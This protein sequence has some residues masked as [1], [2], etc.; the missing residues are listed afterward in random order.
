MLFKDSEITLDFDKKTRKLILEAGELLNWNDINPDIL[1]AMIQTV[2]SS[3]DRSESGMHYTSVENIMKV[4]KPLFLDDLTASYET[5]VAKINDNEDKD[6]T[7]KTKSANRKVYEK[8]LEDLR[9]RLSQIKFFDPACGSGNFLII[10]YKELRRLEIKIVKTLR[11]LTGKHDV[12]LFEE[13]QIKLAQ[14]YG[15]DLDDFAHEVARLSLWIAEHQMNVEAKE[16]INMKQALLPLRD[17]G[18]IT[19]GNALRLDW[20]KI[21][22]HSPTDEI[23][24]IGNP[25]YIINFKFIKRN[26]MFLIPSIHATLVYCIIIIGNYKLQFPTYP[27]KFLYKLTDF[28][29]NRLFLSVILRI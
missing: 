21:V 2:A 25:P 1:G 28:L 22:P 12:N 29:K 3:E 6:T 4:I 9:K 18:N 8:E 23:Y 26:Q 27:F 14:F 24:L 5:I 17:A 20:D 15:I 19:H 16:E 13:S 11:E 10:T 7:A